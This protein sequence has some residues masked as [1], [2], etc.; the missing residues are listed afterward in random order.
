MSVPIGPPWDDTLLRQ[1]FREIRKSERR[2]LLTHIDPRYGRILLSPL[3]RRCVQ[4]PLV[5]A[6]RERSQAS[7]PDKISL[8]GTTT[9]TFEH[10]L[11]TMYLGK[12]LLELIPELREFFP[13]LPFAGLLHDSAGAPFRHV[14]DFIMKLLLDKT[15]ED[16]LPEKL[17]ESGMDRLLI[18]LGLDIGRLCA[19]C[20]GKGGLIGQLLDG[21]LGIDTLDNVLRYSISKGFFAEG[22]GPADFQSRILLP[23]STDV[24]YSPKI[25]LEGLRLGYGCVFLDGSVIGEVGRYLNCRRWMYGHIG[26]FENRAPEAMLRRAMWL[27]YERDEIGPEFFELT[28]GQAFDFLLKRC[29]RRTRWIMRWLSGLKY[30]YPAC[31]CH[32]VVD[33][34]ILPSCVSKFLDDPNSWNDLADGIAGLLGKPRHHVCVYLQKGD[35]GYRSIDL[36]V[37]MP[38]GSLR[39][40]PQPYADR[41]RY[42]VEVFVR[43]SVTFEQEDAIESFTNIAM[44]TRHC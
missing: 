17:A 1:A 35:P 18:R 41:W 16:R 13:E 39:P 28:D 25:I 21:C 33:A 42:Q 15:H 9:S 12:L 37:Q 19:A 3:E 34:Q 14:S 30:F 11:G 24:V 44:R 23:H 38:D 29:N 10:A 5:Q 32:A 26:S 6:M 36:P 22:W 40:F 43:G 27:A 7:I 31:F 2:R 20:R 4:H 8:A